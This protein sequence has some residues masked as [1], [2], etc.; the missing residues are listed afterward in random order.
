MVMTFNEEALV[1]TVS[2][3]VVMF[4]QFLFLLYLTIIFVS[5]YFNYFTTPNKEEVLIDADYLV[6][7][8][9]VESE[10]EITSLDDMLL[11]SVVLIYVFG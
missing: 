10:K 9:V 4:P 7:S 6:C 1:E 2:N 8:I 3:P 5:I 11:A